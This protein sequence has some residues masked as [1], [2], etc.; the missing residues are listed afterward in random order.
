M[1]LEKQ[2]H[3]QSVRTNADGSHR[4]CAWFGPCAYMNDA[5]G[6]RIDPPPM[7][8]GAVSPVWPEEL[9]DML[10]RLITF[11]GK[12]FNSCLPDFLRSGADAIGWHSEEQ[13]VI[14]P[15]PFVGFVSLGE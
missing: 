13:P 9:L 3:W 6:F 8:P 7:P 14:G 12:N 2:I 15:D 5:L 4:F 11:T 1:T 10:H